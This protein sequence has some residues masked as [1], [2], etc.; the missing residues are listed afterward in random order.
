MTYAFP[1]LKRL[2]TFIYERHAIYQ[3]RFEQKLPAP[4]THDEILRTYKFTNVY[5]ELDRVTLWIAEHWRSPF[6]DEKDLWF[7]MVIARLVNHPDTLDEIKS[8]YHWNAA[9]FCRI[10][11]RRRDAGLQ[12]FGGAYIISTG[13]LSMDKAE[14]LAHHVLDPLWAARD[15]VRPRAGDTL[16]AFHG[17]LMSFDGMGSFMAAQVVADMKYVAP[18]RQAKDFW[19]FA[20]SGPGSRRGMSYT[21]GFTPNTKW[22]EHEWRDALNDLYAYVTPHIVEWKFPELHAQDLQNC[23]CEFSKYMRT[24]AGTG[25]PKAK[26]TPHS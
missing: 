23:L 4:W 19:T 18:L 1:R 20:S 3:R 11:A 25:R 12:R 14:Y 8:P 13:G 21:C 26:F 2:L 10:M 17:R 9:Q 16:Q 15:L 24:D 6:K 5:R 22:R 7:A